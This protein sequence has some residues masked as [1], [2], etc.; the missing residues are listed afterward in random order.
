MKSYYIL[1]ILWVYLKVSDRLDCLSMVLMNSNC[2]THSSPEMCPNT[3]MYLD[4]DAK[5]KLDGE[6]RVECGK[7]YSMQ[8]GIDV[9]FIYKHYIS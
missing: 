4:A 6:L 2:Q 3:W 9:A 8:K 5:W 7:F 1:C